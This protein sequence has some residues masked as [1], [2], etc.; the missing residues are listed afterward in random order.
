MRREELLLID[1]IER[2]DLIREVVDATDRDRFPGDAIAQGAVLYAL[3]IIGEASR[4]VS[5]SFAASHARVPW[6]QLVAFRNLAVRVYPEL[7]AVRVWGIATGDVPT[8]R[9]ELVDILRSEFPL[10]AK[11][12][13]EHDQENG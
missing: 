1:I 7:D 10:A 3:V 11:A 4:N 13:E 2:C 5:R 8:L 6:P 12:L 9:T